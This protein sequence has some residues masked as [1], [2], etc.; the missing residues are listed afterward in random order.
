M[1][2]CARFCCFLRV[3]L[4]D[5]QLLKMAFSP[6]ASLIACACSDGSL[7]IWRLSSLHEHSGSVTELFGRG[8]AR[9]VDPSSISKLGPSV[10]PLD[11]VPLVRTTALLA[12]AASSA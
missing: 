1:D 4:S 12:R 6:D 11:D 9:E 8:T 5:I 7:R 3:P 2:V 10:T